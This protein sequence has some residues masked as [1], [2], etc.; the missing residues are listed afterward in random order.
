MSSRNFLFSCVFNLFDL[1]VFMFS[2]PMCTVFTS[3]QHCSVLVSKG[4]VSSNICV[5]EF[6]IVI[7]SYYVIV[8]SGGMR[9]SEFHSHIFG[10]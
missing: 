7:S 3:L 9:E 10:V 4:N 2:F 1:F 5:Q 8:Y 6:E